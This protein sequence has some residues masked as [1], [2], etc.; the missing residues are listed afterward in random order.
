MNTTPAHLTVRQAA[1]ELGITPRA[2][3]HRIAA[4]TL[5]ATKLGDGTSVVAYIIA[6]EDVEA[7]KTSPADRDD[8]QG[9]GGA[10]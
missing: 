10:S 4:G 5:P 7:A 9:Q 2:I 3:L 6:R 1:T 8:V